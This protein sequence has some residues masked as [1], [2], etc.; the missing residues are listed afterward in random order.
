M[1]YRLKQT[2]FDGS[3]VILK[4]V[5]INTEKCTGTHLTVDL[6]PN[7]FSEQFNI[8]IYSKENTNAEIF[9]T[10]PSGRIV[11]TLFSG[12]LEEGS[13]NLKFSAGDVPPGFYYL[14]VIAGNEVI[15]HKIIK[16]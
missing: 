1:Y 10:N 3:S 15:N 16:Q 4:Q 8:N 6:Y 13:N 9:L 12:Y 11:K 14:K 2:D 5:A 7:P